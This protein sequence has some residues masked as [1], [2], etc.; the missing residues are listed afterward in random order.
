MLQIVMEKAY[1]LIARD[2]PIPAIDTDQAL[3]KIERL[4][5]CGSDLQIF[6]GKHKFVTFPIVIGHEASGTIVQTGKD[7]HDF[8]PGDRVV[9]QPQKFCE[10]CIPC[11]EGL[12]NVCENLS[13][14]GVYESG[15]ATEFF[16]VET[17]KLLKLPPEVSLDQGALVEPIAVAVAAVRKS[18]GVKDT[19]I[20]VMGAGPI[21]NLVGQVAAAEGARQV[22]MTD[23]N[24]NRLEVAGRC[25]LNL[26]QNTR[27]I[28]LEETIKNHFGSDGADIIFD[29]AGVK[30]SITQAIQAA[31]RG[32]RLV[33]VAN[34]KESVEIEL[35]L[36]QRK[37]ITL[38]GIMMYIKKDFEKAI[39]LLAQNKINTEPLISKYFDLEQ[40]SDAYRYS[41]EKAQEVMKIL[42]KTDSRQKD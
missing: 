35:V 21:G 32:S 12:H 38:F 29:C 27:D 17:S 41:D 9:I 42:L 10:S 25:G 2:V 3:I 1:T 14:M 19:R 26:S 39:S 22:L 13:I 34:F 33:V 18:L 7:V 15:M 4:G 6:H 11:S 5:V 30:Q 28:S 16:A 31:R 40:I 20:V 36:L 37:E 23:I 8:K 24:D